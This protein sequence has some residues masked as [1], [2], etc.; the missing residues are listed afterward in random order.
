MNHA[1]L[2]QPEANRPSVQV[3]SIRVAY[4]DHIALDDVSFVVPQGSI[5]AV[6]GPSGCGKSTLLR[7]ICGLEPIRS[8]RIEIDG[9]EVSSTTRHTPPERRRMGL[10]PQEGALFDHLSV[11]G[12]IGFGLGPW[13]HRSPGRSER[14]DELLAVTGLT[15][16]AHRRPATLSGGQ[17]Q[18]VALA[19][20]LAPRPVVIGLDEPFSALDTDL[21]AHLQSHV[22]RSLLSEN[23]TG[24]LVTHD[25]EEALAMADHIV[26]LIDGRVRQDAS[27]QTVYAEPADL[28][29]ARLFGDLA[30]LAASA[31]GPIA[32]TPIGQL[33]LRREHHGEGRVLIRPDDLQVAVDDNAPEAV[34]DDVT[35][36]GRDIVISA[37][38]PSGDLVLITGSA[39][40]RFPVPGER[41]RYRQHAPLHFLPGR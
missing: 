16:L 7:A 11:S 40:T 29:V 8:G 30:D 36:R 27:P 13:W 23:A 6:V 5:T 41:I 1:Q 24:L 39:A 28:D 34:V 37:T 12:N 4:G 10:V 35:F 9:K 19:R 15:D 17:R 25:R 22:R 2:N 32:I 3:E 21:R 20:A 26:V 33:T 31:D 14:I 38:T 18:R